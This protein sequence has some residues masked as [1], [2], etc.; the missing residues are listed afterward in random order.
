MRARLTRAGLRRRAY[1]GGP[2]RAGVVLCGALWASVSLFCRFWH[3]YQE[4]EF[5]FVEMV[6]LSLF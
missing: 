2:T 5:P 1:A 4:A 3:L 6:V